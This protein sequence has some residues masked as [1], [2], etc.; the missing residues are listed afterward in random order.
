MKSEAEVNT[1]KFDDKFVVASNLKQ[2]L[3]QYCMNINNCEVYVK[4]ENIRI[5]FQ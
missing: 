3:T 2:I 5:K 4:F 1:A